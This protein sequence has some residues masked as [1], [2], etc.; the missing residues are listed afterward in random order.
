MEPAPAGK[1]SGP[2]TPVLARGARSLPAA[3]AA[4]RLL[5]SAFAWVAGA[6]GWTEAS[7][8]G[9]GD[10]GGTR[11]LVR[12]FGMVTPALCRPHPPP[13]WHVGRDVRVVYAQYPVAARACR[14]LSSSCR[15]SRLYRLAG[16]S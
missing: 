5:A 10:Q 9:V 11:G 13:V 1:R 7:R 16:G 14:L 3:V 2:R 6:V 8:P 15:G 4:R 12:P